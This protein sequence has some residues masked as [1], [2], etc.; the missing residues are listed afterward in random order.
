MTTVSDRVRSVVAAVGCA[1]AV[2]AASAV[3]ASFRPGLWYD[4]LAK[5]PWTPPDWVFA[6][7]WTALYVAIAVAGWL[8]FT[9][10]TGAA[11]RSLWVLQ[12]ILN[13]AWSWLFFGLNRPVLALID[14]V[15]LLGCLAALVGLL[16]VRQRLAFWLLLPYAL[17]VGYAFSLNAGIVWMQAQ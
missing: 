4:A 16:A 8:I 11:V 12:L 10:P 6:P 1:A 15:L 5:P 9:R 7:V 17:W 13:A 14:I 3:G 2:L